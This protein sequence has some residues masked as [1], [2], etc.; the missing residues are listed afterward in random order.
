MD[1][2]AEVN[3]FQH[4]GISNAPRLN[5]AENH[6]EVLLRALRF[7]AALHGNFGDFFGGKLGN[8]H[9][10]RWQLL[11]TKNAAA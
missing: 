1:R 10:G 5:L 9:N 11:L 6:L 7:S 2:S 8:S 4:A 3:R